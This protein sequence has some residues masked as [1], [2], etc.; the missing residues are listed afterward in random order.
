M[1]IQAN[2]T[3]VVSY[4]A[5]NG[6]YSANGGYFETEAIA[7]PLRGLASGSDHLNGVYAYGE[8]GFPSSSYNSTN[9]WVDV[10]FSAS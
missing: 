8:P 5:P 4:H 7:P 3:Y 2:T 9:Y 1:A 10:V 6:F